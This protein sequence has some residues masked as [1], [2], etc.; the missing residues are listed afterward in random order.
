M[1]W[2]TMMMVYSSASSR[3][4]SSILSVEIGSSEEQGS[5]VKIQPA[6]VGALINDAR[7]LAADID[8]SNG[9]IHVIDR[10]LLPGNSTSAVK[11]AVSVDAAAMIRGAINR[12]VPIFNAGDHGRCAKIY[13]ETIEAL[14]PQMQSAEIRG[15]MTSTL[16]SA[17]VQHSAAEQAWTL[18]RG[19]DRVLMRLP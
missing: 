19:M 1:L 12:G 15:M 2:V 4:R 17:A 6:R 14:L 3:I 18:R 7:L 13:R 5:S 11:P 9:V 10:V 8:A 16:N